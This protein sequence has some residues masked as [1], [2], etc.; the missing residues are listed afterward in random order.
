MRISDLLMS[1]SYLNDISSTRSQIN[2]LSN[3][4]ANQSK[5][6][7]PSDSPTATSKILRLQKQLSSTDL[8]L[9]NVKNSLGF[10]DETIR[11]LEAIEGDVSNVLVKLTE[12]NNDTNKTNLENYANQIDQLLKNILDAA[13]ISYD[14]K[15]IFGGTDFADKPFEFVEGPPDEVIANVDIT[16]SSYVKIS[17]NSTQKVNITGGELFGVIDGTDVFN[18]LINIRDTLNA[19][20][21]PDE[22][23]VDAVKDFHQKLL[24]KTSDAGF[25]Y[26]NLENAQTLLESQR[27]DIEGMISEEKDLDV[28][29][30][31][32]EMQNYEYVL[33]ASYKLSSMILPK[34]LMDFL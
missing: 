30:A 6:L 15:Y 4:I 5:I 9:D 21:L 19:G 10:V 26:N 20:N 22:T 33:E 34:S 12:V 2:K 1:Q 31:I 24:N 27:I 16:G 13:N 29:K 14:G 3:Q 18:T 11:G 28:A 7:K 32:I 17:A 23:D 25:I 8:Y